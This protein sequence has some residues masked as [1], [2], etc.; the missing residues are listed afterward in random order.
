METRARCGVEWIGAGWIG[1]ELQI[2]V[3]ADASFAG[4]GVVVRLE[5]DGHDSVAANIG[6]AISRDIEAVA[7]TIFVRHAHNLPFGDLDPGARSAVMHFEVNGDIRDLIISVLAGVEQSI[8]GRAV[9]DNINN[10]LIHTDLLS[11]CNPNAS[12]KGQKIRPAPY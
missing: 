12:T 11:M 9:F 7:A 5:I 4:S 10:F 2:L 6:L 8:A 1:L 3:E